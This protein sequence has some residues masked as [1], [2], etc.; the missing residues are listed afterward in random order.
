M[1][2]IEIPET[3]SNTSAGTAANPYSASRSTVQMNVASV[4]K[5]AGPKSSVAGSSFI[6]VRKTSADPARIPGT[7]SGN[8]TWRNAPAGDRPSE[9]A[10]S[11]SRG[12]TW[13]TPDRVVPTACGRYN[14]T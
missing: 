2:N 1:T 8:T 12:F 14:T 7:M 13:R 6:A 11:T 5:P 3:Q 10:A 4:S 9:R